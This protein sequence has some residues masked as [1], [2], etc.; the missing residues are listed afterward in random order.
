[1][2]KITFV[3]PDDT[4]MEVDAEEGLTLMENARRHDVPGIVAECGGACACA[5]CHVYVDPAW[6]ERTGERTLLEQDMLEFAAEPRETSRLS[7]QIEVT[8][9]LEGL[10]VGVPQEQA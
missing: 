4:K 1:M 6:L 9:D 7:C 10:I 2:V 8:S 5:T 3:L